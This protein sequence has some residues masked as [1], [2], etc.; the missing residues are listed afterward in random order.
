MQ[1]QR[2]EEERI[3][4]AAMNAAVSQAEALGM[5]P[6]ELQQTI[7]QMH[8]HDQHAIVAYPG[9]R[10][11]DQEQLLEDSKTFVTVWPNYLDAE[12]TLF[13]G[14]RIP[15]EKA[16]PN[17]SVH[18]ISDLLV[19][20]E[21]AHIVEQHKRYPRDWLSYGRVRVELKDPITGAPLHPDFPSRRAL[22]LK[23]GES[24]PGLSSRKVRLEAE[25]AALKAAQQKNAAAA[26]ASATPLGAGGG[27]SGEGGGGGNRKKKK[28]KKG[29]K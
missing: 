22:L 26:A 7:D 2:R 6:E 28:G 16:C 5:T 15:K 4:S 23:L 18:D 12:K 14:R 19:Q 3:S 17:P 10:P 8:L 20:W 1:R 13:Q 9:S 11:R 24:I 25:A 21:L 29:R 27:E